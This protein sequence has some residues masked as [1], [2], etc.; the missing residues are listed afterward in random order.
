MNTEKKIFKIHADYRKNNPHI[1]W[2]Y[3]YAHTKKEAKEQFKRTISW[4]DVYRVEE[5]TEE[6]SKT[7]IESPEKHILF[8]IKDKF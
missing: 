7:I 5:C 4:L 6:E 3:I 1:N 2:Y 8:H